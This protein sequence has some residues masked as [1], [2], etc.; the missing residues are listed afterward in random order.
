MG[1]NDKEL[2]PNCKTPTSRVPE[3]EDESRIFVDDFLKA[4]DLYVEKPKTKKKRSHKILQ[5]Q[6]LP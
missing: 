1:E 3:A 5:R 2:S 4:I 6:S